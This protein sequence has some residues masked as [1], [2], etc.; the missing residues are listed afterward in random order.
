VLLGAAGAYAFVGLIPV[1]TPQT[2]WFVAL[3]GA[4][5][6][7]AMVL[8]GLSGSFLLVILGKY[9]YVIAAVHDP[10]AAD[11][12]WRLAVFLAGALAGVLAFTRLLHWCLHH[13]HDETMGLLMGLM[14]GAMRKIWPW[15]HVLETRWVGG[16]EVII[17][18]ENV[19]PP[20]FTAEVALAAGLMVAGAGA[21]FLLE[22]LSREEDPAAAGDR[23][24]PPGA[25]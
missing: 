22:Y 9:E 12:P 21:V 10:L 6:M 19:L 23:D 7:C 11:H 16:R 5:A 1:Q 18:E 2:W 20:A 15:K 14:I 4:V 25:A 8:P 3:C 13:L 24:A 17:R